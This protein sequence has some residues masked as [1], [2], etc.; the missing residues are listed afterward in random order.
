M[1]GDRLESYLRR[2]DFVPAAPPYALTRGAPAIPALFARAHSL[3]SF[4]P[5]YQVAGEG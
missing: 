5:F 3:R 2:G 4:D 1:A